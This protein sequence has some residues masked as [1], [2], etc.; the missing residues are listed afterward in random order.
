[1][2]CVI[3]SFVPLPTFHKQSHNDDWLRTIN[4]KSGDMF[5]I[6]S[7]RSLYGF[8]SKSENHKFPDVPIVA[9]D[10][11]ASDDGVVS[12]HSDGV[13]RIWQL[14]Q[15]AL[16]IEL[17]KWQLIWG[18][19][20]KENNQLR[21]NKDA[22]DRQ[23]HASS[24]KHGKHDPKNERHSGGNTWA[25]GT[26]GSDTAGLGGKGGPYRLDTGGGHDIDQLSDEE[27]ANVSDEVRH[28]ARE[29]AK[30]ALSKRLA[31]IGMGAKDASIYSSIYDRVRHEINLMREVLN[32]VQTKQNER[33][34]IRFQTAG[35]FDDGRI[36]DGAAGAFCQEVFN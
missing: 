9:V 8:E 30:E 26:G 3:S 24:P 18:D 31:E 36:I 20:T 7:P 33:E 14:Q 23:K 11:H 12:L 21:L 34:W 27:K 2:G 28:R 10:L 19:I 1:M 29:M 35:D 22:S 17:G 4:V 25:G 32:G 6:Q 16:A 5:V 15:D 13:I